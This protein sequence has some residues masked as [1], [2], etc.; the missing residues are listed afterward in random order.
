[1]AE[2]IAEN[3]YLIN[4]PLPGNPLK[5][6][7]SYFIKGTR[8]NLLVDTGFNSDA[9]YAALKQG[10]DELCADMENTDLFL[11]HFHADHIGLAGR[12]ASSGSRIYMGEKDKDYYDNSIKPGYWQE[13]LEDFVKLGFSEEEIS[14]NS[15][16]NPMTR[17]LPSAA[18][19]FTGV[20]DGFEIDLGSCRVQCIETPGHTPGHMC[21]Y[22]E[23]RRILFSGDH[24]LFDISPNIT[25]WTGVDNP[26]AMYM[27]SLDRVRLIDIETT[28]PGHRSTGGSCRQRIDELI[29]HHLSRLVEVY[30]IVKKSPG[31]TTYEAASKMKWSIR[32]A[33]WEAFP[34]QQKWFATGEAAAH[35]E[36]LLCSGLI[37][38]K[39]E[40]RKY[41][42]YVS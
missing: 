36:Y 18:T 24:I 14:A 38:R 39:L 21:L 15:S 31:M 9:C 17:Y 23:D 20:P 13:M 42:Y 1:M 30:S 35:L 27:E 2:K 3:I 5:N 40:D 25:S 4:V 26:L 8:R 10:L 29:I 32:A 28:L 11:T 22:D 7:N 12:I 37:A 6:L 19:V 16:V 41:R 33:S 34:V